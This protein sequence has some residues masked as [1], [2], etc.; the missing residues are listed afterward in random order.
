MEQRRE[1]IEE[2][3]ALLTAGQPFPPSKSGDYGYGTG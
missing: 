1:H 2:V 3:A